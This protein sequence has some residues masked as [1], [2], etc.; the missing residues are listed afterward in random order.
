VVANHLHREIAEAL[1]ACGKHVLCEKPLASSIE[2]A[3]SMVKAADASSLV[4]DS[5][6]AVPPP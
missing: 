5:P 2:D 4:A 6:T 1:L 3:E